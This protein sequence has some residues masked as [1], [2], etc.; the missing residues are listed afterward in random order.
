MSS[1]LHLSSLLQ[2][3][4]TTITKMLNAERSTL[5]IN[6]E[7]RNELYTEVGQG[8][9][10]TQI[11]IP[12]DKGIAG[13]VCSSRETINIPHAYADLRFNPAVDRRTGFFT[14]SILCVPVLNKNG[15]T[16][17]V[18]QVLNKRGG[19]FSGEDE[20]RL[21]PFTSQI[22]MALETAKVFDDVQILHN[23]NQSIVDNMPAGISPQKQ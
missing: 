18:T 10:S 16:I 11:R 20:A 3:L 12:N 8:L 7:K 22:S 14:R 23:Y 2:K 21:K 15:K 1:E 6:D 13:A 5:F 4:I 9:G 17:G 19:T